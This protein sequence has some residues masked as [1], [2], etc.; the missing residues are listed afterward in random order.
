MAGMQGNRGEYGLC[1][2]DKCVVDSKC[3]VDDTCVVNDTCVVDDN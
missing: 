3:V 1:M 2:R